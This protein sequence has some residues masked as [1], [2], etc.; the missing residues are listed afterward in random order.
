MSKLS[1]LLSPLPLTDIEKTRR[2]VRAWQYKA[3]RSIVR[4][5]LR[6]IAL[7]VIAGVFLAV[8]LIWI[9]GCSAADDNSEQGNSLQWEQGYEAHR[10][11][12]R[13]SCAAM[14]NPKLVPVS[15]IF[16]LLAHEKQVSN[17]DFSA[18]WSQ[19]GE[20]DKAAYSPADLVKCEAY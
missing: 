9:L 8:I 7:P 15:D 18:G 17:E 6:H 5:I 13:L 4:Y 1:D 20:D 19:S 11:W 14:N 16:R 12:Y 2:P 10:A 3:P